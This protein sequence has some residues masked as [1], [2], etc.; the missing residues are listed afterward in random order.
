MTM[1]E[2]KLLTDM[3]QIPAFE[4]EDQE[5]NFWA[6]HELAA[7]L[8]SRENAEMNDMLPPA[9]AR[10]STPTSIRLDTELERR[11]RALARL[12]ETPYQTL[13]KQFV[14]ERVYEEE[15]RRHLV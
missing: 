1:T 4:N 10:R 13:L 6:T 5:A 8:M 15:K 14:T 11:I 9:R 7:G 3:G 12:M 2:M